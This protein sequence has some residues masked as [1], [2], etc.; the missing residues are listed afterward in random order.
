MELKAH[1]NP[2]KKRILIVDDEQGVLNSLQ[3]ALK[4]FNNEY[5]IYMTSNSADVKK[6]IAEKNIDLL[7]TDILMPEKD[8]IEII[9][10]TQENN[11]SVKIMTI[12]G[13]GLI[14]ADTY[15]DIALEIGSLYSLK[16]PFSIDEFISAIRQLLSTDE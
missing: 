8:G 2:M 11:P 13:G 4:P 14:E 3:R 10:E 16:K 7:I 1:T 5:E 9:N 12:S 6:L 15:L